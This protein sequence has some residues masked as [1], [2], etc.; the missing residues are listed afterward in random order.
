MT[1]R[2]LVV[3]E[4]DPGYGETAKMLGESACCLALEGAEL[5]TEGGILTPASSMGARLIERLRDA[6]MTFSVSG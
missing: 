1:L 6:G 2:G 4:Q 5:E 3:G